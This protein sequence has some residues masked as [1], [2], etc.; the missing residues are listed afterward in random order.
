MDRPIK[1]KVLW[2]M[3][4]CNPRTLLSDLSGWHSSISGRFPSLLVDSLSAFF[5]LQFQY[6]ATKTAALTW[7]ASFLERDHRM[8]LQKLEKG[9][10]PLISIICIWEFIAC[11]KNAACSRPSWHIPRLN[12][13]DPIWIHE[14]KFYGT[15]HLLTLFGWSK[16]LFLS[17]Y[18]DILIWNSVDTHER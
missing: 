2:C 9:E 3:Q 5:H 6:L 11:Q 17:L 18:I 4:W 16:S 1:M 12:C 15:I 10:Q 13:T 8:W 7:P 14:K